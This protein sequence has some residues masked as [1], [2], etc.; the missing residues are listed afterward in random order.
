MRRISPSAP[1]ANL[2]RCRCD[3]ALTP[4]L[5]ANRGFVDANVKLGVALFK[6][7]TMKDK[8]TGEIIAGATWR[9]TNLMA[10]LAENVKMA[11]PDIFADEDFP[12]Q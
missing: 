5:R 1:S 2:A 10:D 12:E 3:A 6:V 4:L 7:W 11:Y 8:Q 9:I